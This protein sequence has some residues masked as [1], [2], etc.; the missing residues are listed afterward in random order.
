MAAAYVQGMTIARQDLLDV[1]GQYQAELGMPSNERSAVA[2]QQRQRQGDVSTYHYIDNQAKMIRQ[3]GRILLDLIPAVY[4]TTRVTRIMHPDGSDSEVILSPNA[5]QSMLRM[6]M[7]PNGQP[8]PVGKQQAE[9]IN[10]DD[11]QPDVR[12]IFN[13]TIGSYGVEAD[14]GPSYGTQRQEAANAFVTIMAQNPN[15]FQLVA[16]SGRRTV[17]STALT[18]L[19]NASRGASLRNIARGTTRKCSRSP[20]RPK[21]WRSRRSS[22]CSRPTRR[23]PR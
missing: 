16:T 11:N 18:Y 15:A 2:I 8:V 21:R 5:P 23:S 20:S 22:S 19:R 9:Q 17:I 13:P 12:I 1:T 6:A 7:G 14:V 4:D 10:Q 3:V